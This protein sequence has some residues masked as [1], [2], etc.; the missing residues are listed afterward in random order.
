MAIKVDTLNEGGV[1]ILKVTGEVDLESS[2][3][4]HDQ[5]TKLIRSGVPLKVDLSDVPYMD[6]SGIAVLTQGL[7]LS[8]QKGVA[9]ALL[10]P[11][12]QVQ[13]V[14]DLALLSQLFT[15]EHTDA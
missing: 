13:A 14:I 3:A 11:S 1:T 7:K 12:T 5:I 10:N 9:Y 2:P 8:Q 4:L 15:I 6:S